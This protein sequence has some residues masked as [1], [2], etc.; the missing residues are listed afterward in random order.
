MAGR[1]AR[2]ARGGAPA[3]PRTAISAAG[4]IARVAGPEALVSPRTLGFAL[5][6]VGIVPVAARGHGLDPASLTLRET[7]PGVFDVRW[8]ASALRVPGSDVR[9]VLPARC[10]QT[11]PARVDEAGDHVALSWTID[12]GADGLAGARI[13]IDDLAAAKVNALV[14][15]TRLESD[16][17]QTLLGPRRSAFDVPARA[18]RVD[19]VREYATLGMAHILSGP[20]HLLFVLGLL[21]LVSASRLLVQTITAFTVGHSI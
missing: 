1:R 13:A 6:L 11:S 4:G 3:R 15:V 10:R 5:A 19:V 16:P 14:S 20:D 8:R 7:T 9:P 18:S 2:A 17:I 21:L 12:C